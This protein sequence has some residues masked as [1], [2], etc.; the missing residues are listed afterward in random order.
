M[1][2]EHQ[3]ATE[4]IDPVCGMSIAP[5]DATGTI[6]TGG[7][8]IIFCNASCEVKF[9]EHPQ[10]YV[11]ATN[12]AAKPT[13]RND[14]EYT[15]PMHPEVRQSGPGSASIEQSSEHPLAGAIVAAAQQKSIRLDLVSDFE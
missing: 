3:T 7:P 11:N 1:D 8:P 6:D 9:R 13:G 2:H 10:E 4:V 12:R 14:V 15:C 5:E